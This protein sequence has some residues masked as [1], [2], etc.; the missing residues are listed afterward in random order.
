MLKSLLTLPLIKGLD[1]DD[2][3]ATSLRKQIIKEKPFLKK[4]YDEWYREITE[5]FIDVQAPILEIGSGAGHLSESFQVITSDLVAYSNIQIVLNGQ[6]LPF[7]ENSLKGIVL[8]GVLH[9]LPNP[10]S[11]LREA[12]RC[13]VPG[14]KMFLMEPWVT[15][16]SNLIYRHFHHEPF[17]PEAKD[18]E[19][20]T[21]GPLAGANQALSWIIFSRDRERFEKEFPEWRIERIEPRMPFRYLLSGGFS[22]RSFMPGWSHEAWRTFEN[23]LQPVMNKLATVAYIV[24]VKVK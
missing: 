17:D 23:C 14:G 7:S 13:V 15:A 12:T 16:W 22:F 24:L 5:E 10:W 2:P 18:W 9:H 6:E 8:I 19:F 11:F 20:E 3:R 4:I 21:T 1:I